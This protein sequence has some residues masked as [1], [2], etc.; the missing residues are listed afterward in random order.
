[1]LQSLTTSSRQDTGTLRNSTSKF[2]HPETWHDGGCSK[3][4]VTK[5]GGQSWWVRQ[6]A[7]STL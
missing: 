2:D 5:K 3:R 6:K 4:L 1:M 7:A